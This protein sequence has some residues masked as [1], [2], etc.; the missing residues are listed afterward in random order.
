MKIPNV[1]LYS[2]L[3]AQGKYWTIGTEVIHK[4]QPGGGFAVPVALYSSDGTQWVHSRSDLSACKPEM[5]VACTTQGC[6]SANGAI[7]N[8]FAEKPSYWAFA[9][10]PKLTPKWAST[11][12]SICFIGSALHCTA[13]TVTTMASAG[14]GP[15]PAAV[16]PGPLGNKTSEGPRC[17]ACELDQLLVDNKVQGTFIIKLSLNI[18][19]NGTVTAVESDDAPTP[20]IKSQIEQ[21]AEQWIFEPY[22]K[23]GVRVNLKLNTRVRV[24]VVRPR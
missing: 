21:Q 8:V 24:S 13:L 5:C 18:S 17:I 15:I 2:F 7:T 4:D 22:T 9:P 6:L 19:K 3:R 10:N 1:T 12:S 11:E 14:E 23:D 20:E 16:A